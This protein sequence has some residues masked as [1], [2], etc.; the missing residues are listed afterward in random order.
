MVREWQPLLC[1]PLA[2]PR[3]L[4][5][6]TQEADLW[7]WVGLGQ[8]HLFSHVFFNFFLF[9]ISYLYFHFFIFLF[10]FIYFFIFIVISQ[11]FKFILVY[12]YF[13]FFPQF[14]FYFAVTMSSD[15]AAVS[16]NEESPIGDY[17]HWTPLARG[18]LLSEVGLAHFDWHW[19]GCKHHELAR[20]LWNF[21]N[22][23]LTA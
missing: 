13:Y 7:W 23:S 10:S 17:V 1:E 11:F 9:N 2:Q 18:P 15:F 21:S 14:F 4:S 22:S 16:V 20:L 19:G 3:F 8:V 12:C 6:V 5:V